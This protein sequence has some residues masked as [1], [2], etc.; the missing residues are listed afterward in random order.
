MKFKI[1]G[2]A[3]I[4]NTPD[5]DGQTIHP[6]AFSDWLSRGKTIPMLLGFDAAKPIGTLNVIEEDN[7]GLR[8]EGELESF[9][10]ETEQALYLVQ[11]N[12]LNGLAIGFK[13]MTDEEVGGEDLKKID[14]FAIGVVQNPSHVN[15]RI[16]SVILPMKR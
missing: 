4:F 16:T 10:E 2:Y 5:G 15:T 14:L 3:A 11:R 6:G 12:V 7:I 8:V 13:Y 1:E 9:D